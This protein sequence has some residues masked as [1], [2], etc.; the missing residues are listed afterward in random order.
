MSDATAAAGTPSGSPQATVT[1]IRPGGSRPALFCPPPVSGSIYWC[2]P[3]HRLLPADQPLYA[4]DAP[5]LDGVAEPLTTIS[6]LAGCYIEALRRTQPHGPYLLAG[7]SMGGAIA[8][9]MAVRLASAGEAIPLTILIDTALPEPDPG[10][11]LSITKRFVNDVA[12]AR[13]RTLDDV[14]IESVFE[15]PNADERLRSLLCAADLMPESVDVELVARRY[16]LF[17]ANTHAYLAYRPSRYRGRVALVNAESSRNTTEEWRTV[18][19]GPVTHMTVPGDHHSM[20]FPPHVERLALS[21]D[22]LVASLHDQSTLVTAV[23]DDP[24]TRV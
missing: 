24:G 13:G 4:F 20:W 9:E 5:G 2:M 8:Y 12:G 11:E 18:C 22:M 17:R 23:P 1:A 21:L 7:Y 15:A 14:A 16:R 3:L 19:D 6:D 10:T